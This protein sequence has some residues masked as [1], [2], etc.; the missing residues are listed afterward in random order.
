[1]EF[2]KSCANPPRLSTPV[3]ASMGASKIVHDRTAAIGKRVKSPRTRGVR[4]GKAT[5]SAGAGKMVELEFQASWDEDDVFLFCW[6]NTPAAKER[7]RKKVQDTNQ[8]MEA[9][10]ESVPQGLA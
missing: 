9:W 8:R 1:M 2:L 7:H 10:R 6:G 3:P 5:A 4:A